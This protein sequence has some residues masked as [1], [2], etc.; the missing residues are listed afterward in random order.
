MSFASVPKTARVRGRPFT[1]GNRGRPAGAKNR[2]TLVRGVLLRG[3]DERLL[4]KA[5]EMALNGDAQILKFFL[6]R[7]LPR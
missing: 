4:R 1:Q 2:S 6:G 5:I 7:I 3:D